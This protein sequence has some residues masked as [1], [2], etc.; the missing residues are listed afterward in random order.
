MQELVTLTSQRPVL[1]TTSPT[2]MHPSFVH[3][4]CTGN[5]ISSPEA[6]LEKF[7]WE[8]TENLVGDGLASVNG[9]NV[10][11]TQ[12]LSPYRYGLYDVLR[13]RQ[14]VYARKLVAMANSKSVSAVPSL[15]RQLTEGCMAWFPPFCRLSVTHHAYVGP[16][17]PSKARMKD[18]M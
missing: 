10:T 16:V 2:S 3:A 8:A 14:A 7:A 11:G 15:V 17:L 4:W 9:R 5:R 6:G 13:P 18:D 1:E 12:S